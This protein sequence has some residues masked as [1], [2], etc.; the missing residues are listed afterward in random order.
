MYANYHTH[1]YLCRHA[2]GTVD[3]Y[4]EKAIEAGIKELGFSDH[5]P[6]IFN[7]DYYSTYRMFPEEI[8]TYVK[9]V[10]DTKNKYKDDIKI[11]LG[12]EMEYYPECFEKTLDFILQYE[13]DY[14]ILGQHF[15]NNEMNQPYI[16]N[17]TDNEVYLKTYVNQV[18]EGIKTGVFSYV[19]HPDIVN[20]TGDFK[21]YESEMRKLCECAKEYSMPL[22]INLLGI[23]DNRHY[24]Y[25]HFWKI[26][27][28]VGN[29]VVMGVDAHCPEAFSHETAEKQARELAEKYNI[30][31]IEK[32]NLV[33]PNER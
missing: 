10:T 1:T 24:P 11:Y 6:C 32:L 8:E 12:Y 30:T 4:V 22:E 2:L 14:L 28:D 20:L 23:R 15:I 9:L 33:S 21:I 16:A 26:A 7:S 29:D 19:A 17:K 25:E 27:A 31:P 18:I 13:C 3:G 5:N